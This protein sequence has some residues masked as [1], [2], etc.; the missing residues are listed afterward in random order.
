MHDTRGN[1]ATIEE[2][3]GVLYAWPC[4]PEDESTATVVWPGSYQQDNEQC[5]YARLMEDESSKFI[6][7]SGEHYT[8]LSQMR[9]AKRKSLEAEFGTAA[10]RVQVPAGGL[11][12]WSSRTIHAGAECGPR[13]AQAVCLEPVARRSEQ[14]RMAKLR[15]AAL[16]LPSMHWASHGV[17]HDCI[18]RRD[19]CLETAQ[20][21]PRAGDGQH[22]TV[23]PLRSAI[24]PW[25]HALGAR[26]MLGCAEDRT[27]E[28]RE[29][30]E[31]WE[32]CVLEEAKAIL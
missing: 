19:G 8:T 13:L 21:E 10:R 27:L 1:L 29:R 22:D 23:L 7:R 31:L 9:G 14:E 4:R 3:Q 12:L 2:Y 20:V 32:R 24:R 15:L 18:R 6:G 25:C 26:G 30:H 5:A 28:L 11:L 16:G 17:Q